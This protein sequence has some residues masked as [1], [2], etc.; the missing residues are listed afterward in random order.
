[1]IRRQ[2]ATTAAHGSCVFSPRVSVSNCERKLPPAVSNSRDQI[3]LIQASPECASAL[4]NKKDTLVCPWEEPCRPCFPSLHPFLHTYSYDSHAICLLRR[5]NQWVPELGSDTAS[6]RCVSMRKLIN[7]M[8][9]TKRRKSG[10]RGYW[11]STT[12]CRRHLQ[13]FHPILNGTTIE[14]DFC[15]ESKV[16][17]IY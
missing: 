15:N 16:S 17:D 4:N 5:E 11:Y 12:K 3:K 8:N 7:R 1:M 13:D 10:S 14:S 6:R 9:R 2:R